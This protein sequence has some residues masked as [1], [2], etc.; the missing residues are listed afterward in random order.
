MFQYLNLNY[1]K[2]VE[3]YITK[4]TTAPKPSNWKRN[5]V[6]NIVNT[7]KA[8]ELLGMKLIWY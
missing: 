8:G 7:A 3:R 4:I 2:K 5:A 6:E 1:D